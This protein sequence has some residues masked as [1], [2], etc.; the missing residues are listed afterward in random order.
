MSQFLSS[1][2]TNLDAPGSQISSVYYNTSEIVVKQAEMHTHIGRFTSSLSSLAFSST[3]QVNIPSQDVIHE[4]FLHIKLP[5]TVANQ[6]LPRAWIFDLIREVSWTWGASN[7]SNLRLSG[8]SIRQL[9]MQSASTKEKRS[10]LLVLAG[11]SFN[12]SSGT[13][14]P[15]GTVILPFPWSNTQG[16]DKPKGF[17]TSLLSNNIQL[18]ITLN[19]GNKIYGGSA[20]IPTAIQSGSVFLR[21]SEF[22]DRSNSLKADLMRNPS[23]L[24]QVPFLHKTSPSPKY[25]IVMDGVTTNTVELLEFL[26]SDLMNIVF[27]VHNTGLQVASGTNAPTPGV[28]AELLDI[29]L[30]WNGQTIYSAPGA[31]ARLVNMI[32][33]SGAS[34]MDDVALNQT[35]PWAA[36][37]LVSYIYTIPFGDMKNMNFSGDGGYYDNSGRYTNQTM[38][39]RFKARQIPGASGS[40][41]LESTY[42]FSSVCGIQNG[43]ATIQFA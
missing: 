35:T 25:N 42:I 1:T 4:T 31:S 21:Q 33:D 34:G 32:F 30:L 19:D 8:K 36:N 38:S 23:L 40:G 43:V 41:Q 9:A 6:T 29:E 11:E 7:V 18:Q 27:S 12:G 26:E 10:E 24:Y 5:P 39:L 16:D 13:I 22:A 2:R 20:A 28:S 15:E 17:D 14:S 37:A 3:S